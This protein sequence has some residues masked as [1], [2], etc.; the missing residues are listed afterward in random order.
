MGDWEP[1]NQSVTADSSAPADS[2]WIDISGFQRAALGTFGN[3]PIGV[4]RAPGY[5]NLDLVLSKRF[6]VGGERYLEFRAEAFNALNH[7]QF[8]APARDINI[9][10][11][12]GLI[13]GTTGTPRVIELA[14][15]F[16]F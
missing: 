6:E 14:L 2:R 1:A 5:T 10:N 7:P 9:P 11:T 13:T 4:A 3:C 8:N 15:K 16:Y 12:F